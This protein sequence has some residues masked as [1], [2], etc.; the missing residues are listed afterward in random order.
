MS[1][2]GSFHSRSARR[3]HDDKRVASLVAKQITKVILQ[4][5]CEL[6]EN[7]S[8]S[9]EESWTDSPKAT[10]SFKQFKACGPK[11]FTGED[12]HT[13]MFQWFDSIEI[14]LRQSNYPDNL[15]TINATG[16]FQ[17]CA[18]D[19]WTA[20]RNK[21]GNDAAYGLTWD[22]LKDLMMKEFCPPHE[23]QKL[24]DE[25]WHL[26]QKDGD[27]AGLTAHFKQLSIICPGQVSM[28]EITIKKYIRAL[29]DCV[30][31]FVQ[32]AKT[33]TMEETF[34]LALRS[35]TSES[36]LGIGIKLP[37]ISIKLPPL[38]P[39]SLRS[40]QNPLVTRG[41]TTTTTVAKIALSL[42]PPRS[43]LYLPNNSLNT[44]K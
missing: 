24:E 27:N 10:F 15:R 16:V 41:R 36:K 28:P 22:E 38:K 3:N 19:W 21:R 14:T 43:K 7:A 29:P 37:R 1:S 5:V 32:A 26:K 6:N 13:A 39:P 42:L 44:A 34:L 2:F 18:L 11:E 33:S 40:L 17:S 12:G 8:K 25:F 9:S 23:L 20:E 31:D 30:T 35:T 4:I